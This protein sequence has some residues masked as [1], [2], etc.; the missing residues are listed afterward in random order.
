MSTDRLY[1]DAV[2]RQV[3]VQRF[4]EGLVKRTKSAFRKHDAKFADRFSGLLLRLSG[5]D[6]DRLDSGYRLSRGTQR[7]KELVNALN[8][9]K[10]SSYELSLKPIAELQQ[11]GFDEAEYWADRLN[12]HHK[13]DGLVFNS[14]EK[15]NYNA[16]WANYLVFGE[17]MR[18]SVKRWSIIRSDA[19]QRHVRQE[20]HV[21]KPIEVIIRD[22]GKRNGVL[23]TQVTSRVNGLS[24]K[25]HTNAT[26]SVSAGHLALLNDNKP[27]RDLMHISVL[28]SRTSDICT[29]RHG[30]LINRDLNGSLPPLHPNCR[31]RTFPTAVKGVKL[32]ENDTVGA[33]FKR[34]SDAEK[35]RIL[36]AKRYELWK[37]GQYKY[38][39]D[40]ID[41]S[42]EKLWTLDEL[43]KRS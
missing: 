25:V 37:T 35:R 17:T 41:P 21:N 8:D 4:I 26:A 6:V 10:K 42:R 38:P 27:I 36:G 11:L 3:K 2:E 29:R 14:P 28:D 23:D 39:Q 7:T 15:G 33:W 43:K 22:I 1:D 24:G 13:S 30:K 12:F 20:A 19:L 32:P 18:D 40:F 5:R 34:Q 16:V 9:F 31:S